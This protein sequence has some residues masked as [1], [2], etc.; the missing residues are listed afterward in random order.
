MNEV[1][2]LKWKKLSAQFYVR[3]NVVQIAKELVG[4]ILVTQLNGHITAGRIVETE[5]YNGII[6]KASHAFGGRRTERT[7]VMYAS[8]GVA[9]V[10]L[11]YGI[12]HLFNVVTNKKNI[13]QAVLIRAVEPLMGM[14][15]ML[16]RTKKKK[17]DFTLT[18]GP[19]NVSKSFGIATKHSGA[20]LL[21]DLIFIADDGF[22]VKT[23]E[24]TA[25]TRIG[26]EYS[27]DDAL[28]PY[29]FIIMNNR[30]VSGKKK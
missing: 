22:E 19:G 4:K 10:Y 13:P 16:K 1:E 9:Y 20:D 3:N 26:V 17:L 11:C 14:D 18:K 15:V 24:W 21:K 25:T 6:D 12:H 7:E 29:R 23:N 30:F 8:G 28:L 27:G 2:S 5:A